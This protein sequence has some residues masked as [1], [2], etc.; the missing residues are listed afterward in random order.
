MN[1]VQ[2]G[3]KY[4]CTYVTGVFTQDTAKNGKLE[5]NAVKSPTKQNVC[6]PATAKESSIESVEKI[7]PSI[8]PDSEPR[9]STSSAV[10][11]VSQVA[12]KRDSDEPS[13]SVTV[14]PEKSSD[15]AP[16]NESLSDVLVLPSK[17]NCRAVL[18]MMHLHWRTMTRDLQLER[19]HN[20]LIWMMNC[21]R[22]VGNFQQSPEYECWAV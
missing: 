11:K 13:S 15:S 8:V 5:L 10:E 9:P 2:F 21:R 12:S 1:F 16:A 17:D 7:V 14:C 3:S 19:T 6:G 4:I 22:W 18:P 20:Q